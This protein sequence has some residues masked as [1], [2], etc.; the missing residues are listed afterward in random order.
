MEEAMKKTKRERRCLFCGGQMHQE[1]EVHEF[2][3]TKR[4]SVTI[5]DAPVWVCQ[6]CSEREVCICKPAALERM[7]AREVVAKVGPLCGD[8][9]T[10]LRRCLAMSGRQ[11]AKRLGVAAETVSRYET[12]ST[13]IPPAMDRLIRSLA[14]LWYLRQG[15]DLFSTEIVDRIDH[16][17]KA[18]PLRLTVY[19]GSGSW[20]RRAAA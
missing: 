12:G 19:F 3:I 16:K 11:M 17:A 1:T 10:F 6:K 14:V 9:L 4:W 5:A 18:A 8:E 13:P 2:T 20:R 7:I 15:G